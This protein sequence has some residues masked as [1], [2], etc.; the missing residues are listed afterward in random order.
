M[1]SVVI[2]TKDLVHNVKKIKEYAKK[3]GKDDNGRNVKIIAVV[4]SNG[5][6]LDLVKYTKFLID[7]GIDLFAVSTVEEAI[8]LREEGIKEDILMFGLFAIFLL[9][10]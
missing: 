9:Y 3:S 7:Q 6:G 8:R 2:E 10:L 4:K 1:K 5:Y